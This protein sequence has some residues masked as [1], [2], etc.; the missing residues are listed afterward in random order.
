M[1]TISINVV[2]DSIDKLTM[3]L[4][5]IPV[6][7]KL[8]RCLSL[9]ITGIRLSLRKIGTFYVSQFNQNNFELIGLNSIKC[10]LANDSQ[11]SSFGSNNI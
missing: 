5:K 2:I 8:P 6:E 10:N 11:T 9:Q 7:I 4:S 3:F 1:L